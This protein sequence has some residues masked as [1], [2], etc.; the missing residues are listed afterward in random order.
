MRKISDTKR[1]HQTGLFYGVFWFASPLLFN[2]D[3]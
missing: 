1:E 2:L 3:N